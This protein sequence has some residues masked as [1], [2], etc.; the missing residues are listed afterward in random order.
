MQILAET[1][2]A[3]APKGPPGWFSYVPMILIVVIIYMFMFRGPK[4]ERDKRKDMLAALKKNDRVMTIG[5][6]VGTVVQVRDDEVIV[7]VDE[8]A[9]VKM[10]FI[11]NSIQ[12]VLADDNP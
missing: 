11:R 3:P 2:S 6:I 7:K 4:K 5:G 1:T 12:R 8:S 10:T 9:N